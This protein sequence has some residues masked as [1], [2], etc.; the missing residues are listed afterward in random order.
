MLRTR[1]R[2][3]HAVVMRPLPTG[4]V[5]RAHPFEIPPVLAL[6]TTDASA[7]PLQRRMV[8]AGPAVAAASMLAAVI[9]TQASGVPLRDPDGVVGRRLLIVF[10][11][12]GGLVAL[13][14]LVRAARLSG[15]RLPTLTALAIVRR[16]RWTV[17]RGL[18][19]FSAL[20]SFYVTYLAYRNLK[21]VVP[22]LRPGDLFDHQ[23]SELDRDLFAGSDPAAL[24][25][26][27]L[28]TGAATHVLSAAYMLFFLFIPGTLA[29]ALV[30][31]VNLRAGIFYVTAQSLNWLIGA[32]SYFLLPSLGPVYWDPAAFSDLPASGVSTLQQILLDQRIEFLAD[33]AAGSAQ[34]IAAFSSLHVSI[35]LTGALAAHVLGLGRRVQ[36][37]AWIL[38]GLTT[39][40]TIHLGWHYVIDDVGGVVVAVMA[41]GLAGTLT[42]FEVRPAR[43]MSAPKAATA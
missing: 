28:G 14:A 32:G 3:G 7:E 35:F 9:A 30:Y 8:L 19:V 33:P 13:D 34:S 37:A 27:V 40:A 21:S 36:L 5:P 38:V 17:R 10:A 41:V 31:S 39:L 18:I 20:V 4:A 24:L 25:H 1:E 23:L 29:F 2:A 22:L 26:A 42:G 12:V 43:R 6:K 11:F 16:E 15:R